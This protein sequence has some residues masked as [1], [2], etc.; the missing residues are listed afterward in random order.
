MVFLFIII[1]IISKYTK[2][3]SIVL[4]RA[5]DGAY[6]SSRLDNWLYWITYWVFIKLNDAFKERRIRTII[7]G[8]FPYSKMLWYKTYV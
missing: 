8:G 2:M 6:Q 1:I 7:Y 3:R 4:Y 5:S